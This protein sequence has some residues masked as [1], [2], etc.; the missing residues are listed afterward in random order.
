MKPAKLFGLSILFA[1][2]LSA[3]GGK[4]NDEGALAAQ[5]PESVTTAQLAGRA[6]FARSSMERSVSN[7]LLNSDFE[8][9]EASWTISS[10]VLTSNASLAH[11]GSQYA[12][13]GGYNNAADA[14]SQTVSIPAN[15]SD[16]SLQFWYRIGTNE[17]SVSTGYDFLRVYVKNPTT[18]ATLATLKTYSNL[19]ATSGWVQSEQIDLAAYKG[20]SIKLQF[21]ATTDSSLTSSFLIDDVSVMIGAE[22]AGNSASSYATAVQQLYIAY[23]GRPADPSGLANFSASL[24]AANAPTTIQGLNAA[25]STNAAVRSLVDAFGTS[26][27]SSTLYTGGTSAFVNAI[28]QNVLN[29]PAATAGLQFWTNAIDSGT[30]TRGNAALSIMAGALSNSTAQGLIDAQV[31]NNKVSVG[32][33]FTAALTS[34]AQVN[35]YRGATAAATVRTMLAGVTNTTDTTAFQSTINSTV[36]ALVSAGTPTTPT[37]PSASPFVGTYT[38]SGGDVTVTFD[39]DSSGRINSCFSET[40]VSCSGSVTSSGVLSLIGNDGL[41]PVDT[42]AT[43]A[44]AISSTGSVSG[45]YTGTSVSEGSFSGSFSGSRTSTSI[46]QVSVPAAQPGEASG[47]VS[48]DEQ[49]AGRLE[50]GTAL[51]GSTG[52]NDYSDWYAVSLTAGVH[53]TFALHGT[54]TSSDEYG[55]PVFHLSNTSLRFL[56]RSHGVNTGTTTD[57]RIE[58][59][60]S[61]SGTYYLGVSST[62]LSY[63]VSVSSTGVVGPIPTGDNLGW[64]QIGYTELFNP[65]PTSSSSLYVYLVAGRSYSFDIFSSSWQSGKR[66]IVASLVD[67]QNVMQVS[68][69]YPIA[70]TAKMSGPHKLD[71]PQRDGSY[72]AKGEETRG[73]T[74]SDG[75][76]GDGGGGGGVSTEVGPNSPCVLANSSLGTGPVIMMAAK[77]RIPTACHRNRL[78]TFGWAI[79]ESTVADTCQA[80]QNPARNGELMDARNISACY[81]YANG[82]VNGLSV[83]YLCRVFYDR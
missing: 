29:R 69:A 46:T 60:P 72:A 44:G 65:M 43:L 19:N 73:D 83:P 11:G 30:L 40:S 15:A 59:T 28:F 27:E 8:S 62:G 6:F 7:V 71:V 63:T 74:N 18:D 38:I 39:V 9:G 20:Q 56:T 47:D 2:L 78:N 5:T 23:F 79:P 67:P 36:S 54:L 3:C 50:V 70:Y 33:S 66:G 41:I 77:A 55:T 52:A 31:V 81:C 75:G 76:G 37:T 49:T 17:T 22:A 12:W 25:Y 51:T 57:A 24:A 1:V 10:G 34:T 58:Y 82:T 26:T 21:A 48:G 64:L 32:A 16:A 4:P 42:S 13:L 80:A 14:V 45:T 61:T 53:Y 68:R 35:A